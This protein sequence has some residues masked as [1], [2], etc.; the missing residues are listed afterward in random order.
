MTNE[1]KILT[2]SV[3]KHINESVNASIFEGNDTVAINS[4]RIISLHQDKLTPKEYSSFDVD[5]AEKILFRYT[6][7]MLKKHEK[8]KVRI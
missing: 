2:A 3:K 6:D 5:K 4:D 8:V 1:E 7:K